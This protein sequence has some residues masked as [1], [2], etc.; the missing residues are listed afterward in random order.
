MLPG[1]GLKLEDAEIDQIYQD[2]NRD[3]I[4][5]VVYQCLKRWTE[6]FGA[7]ATVGQLV[8]SAYKCGGAEIEVIDKF[9]LMITDGS[10]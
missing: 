3:G 1:R 2:F 6:K 9:R 10:T 4:K 5:E 7:T 8:T